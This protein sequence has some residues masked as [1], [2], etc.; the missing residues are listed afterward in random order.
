MIFSP[1]GDKEGYNYPL[2]TG[3]T[4]VALDREPSESKRLIT[5]AL[6]LLNLVEKE[7]VPPLTDISEIHMEKT[8]GICCFTQG[9]GIEVRMGW[10]DFGEKLRRLSI[11]WADLRRKGGAAV[12]IDCSD[13]KRMVVKR[14]SKRR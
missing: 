10:D 13:L 11:I 6:E 1:A 8:S 12:S 2:L 9:E 7:K 14:I 3:L 5:K 4:R